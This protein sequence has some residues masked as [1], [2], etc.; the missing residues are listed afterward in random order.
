MDVVGGSGS[1]ERRSFLNWL[2]GLWATGVAAAVLYPVIRY[3]VPPG[4]PRSRDRRRSPPARPR[5]C[6]RTPGRIVPFGSPPAIVIRTAA[7]ELRAFSG[8]CTH[9]PAPCSI[10]PT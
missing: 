9:L 2:F 6:A 1:P 3:L 7:G 10:D 5:R 8:T 4:D